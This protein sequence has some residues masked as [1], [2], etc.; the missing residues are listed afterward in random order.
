MRTSRAGPAD[1]PPSSALLD[2]ARV[3]ERLAVS[4][5]FVRRLVFER[6][7]P[8]LKIG[9]F[10]RFDPVEVERWIAEARVPEGSRR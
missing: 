3:A 10:V 8:F 7:L 6:R 4:E 5:R 9:Q 2:I 1:T